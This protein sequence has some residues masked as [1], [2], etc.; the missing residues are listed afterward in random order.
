MN[1]DPTTKLAKRALAQLSMLSAQLLLGMA[2]NLI[3]LPSETQGGSKLATTIFLIIH[4]GIGVGLLAG[5]LMTIKRARSVAPRFV[6]HAWTG[7]ALVAITFAAGALTAIQKS[8][9]WSY[10]MAVGF[11]ATFWLYG[12]MYIHVDRLRRAN[13]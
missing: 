8:N 11:L 9:W 2:V 4:A 3:G 13:S 12:A 10:A 6:K 5:S 7:V 1:T